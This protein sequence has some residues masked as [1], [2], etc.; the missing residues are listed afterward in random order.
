MLAFTYHA[1]LEPVGK[2]PMANL[3]LTINEL[4]N[5]KGEVCVAL[6]E[7]KAGFPE[8]DEQAVCN[9]C[10]AIS[11]LPMTV[12]FEVPH[13]SYAVSLLHDENKDGELNTNIV[14]IPKE[15]IGF[16]NDPR[17]IKGTPSFEKTRFEFNEDN[18][19]VEIAVKYF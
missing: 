17:I 2:N 5:Q 6:F 1:I 10:F 9:Q 12:D 4:R 15:G 18:Q 16:S 14:G 8:D 13:G 3:T 19:S 7:S 11:A